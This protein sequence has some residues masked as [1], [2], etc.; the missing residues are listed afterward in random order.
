MHHDGKLVLNIF[1]SLFRMQNAPW[2]CVCARAQRFTSE[3]SIKKHEGIKSA[4]RTKIPVKV[5]DKNA[6][7]ITWTPHKFH[8]CFGVCEGFAQRDRERESRFQFRRSTS[9]CSS[10]LETA[11][12]HQISILEHW[13]GCRLR[14]LLI[15]PETKTNRHWYS[16]FRVDRKN[17][18]KTFSMVRDM[19]PDHFFNNHSIGNTG[20]DSARTCR[21][22]RKKKSITTFDTTIDFVFIAANN[23]KTMY[24]IV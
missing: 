13:I 11:L 2:R 23:R 3:F 12:T 18:G 15:P 7:N 8:S 14:S 10:T 22:E 21:T 6:V 19:R 16:H 4:D 20:N 24:V 5:K 1:H 17:N 9:A